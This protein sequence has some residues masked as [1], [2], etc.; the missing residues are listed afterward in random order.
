MVTDELKPTIFILG[1][2][3]LNS[4]FKLIPEQRLLSGFIP[5]NKDMACMITHRRSF[6]TQ[7]GEDLD[8]CVMTVEQQPGLIYDFEAKEK[9]TKYDWYYEVKY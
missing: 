8:Q 6:E 5:E 1:P 3:D 2:S 7:D 9:A 4:L